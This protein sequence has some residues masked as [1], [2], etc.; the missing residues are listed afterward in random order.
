MNMKIID[1]WTTF[2]WP[3]FERYPLPFHKSRSWRCFYGQ[4]QGISILLVVC[5][6][7]HHFI[8]KI[9][10]FLFFSKYYTIETHACAFSA[11]ISST[12][13]NVSTKM[14]ADKGQKI[15]I[16]NYGVL[17]SPEERTKLIIRSRVDAQ[18]SEFHSFFGRIEDT[19]NYFRDLLTFI[20]HS[21]H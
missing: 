19:K 12:V 20:N 17:S 7:H 10:K 14:G 13:G 15:S 8:C 11:V 1:P 6:E 21:N 3:A 9:N 2:F 5:S 16:A 4:R 18:D